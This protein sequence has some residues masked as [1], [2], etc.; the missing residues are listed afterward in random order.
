MAHEEIVVECYSG[1][2]ADERP[3]AFT[4]QGRRLDV[5][6]IIDRWYEGG[7]T[8]GRPEV[9]YF[10]VKTSGGSVFLLRYIRASDTW[11]IQTEKVE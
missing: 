4:F 3:T 11:S 10:K 9:N 2:K 6:E 1:H 7:L 5:E 8:A